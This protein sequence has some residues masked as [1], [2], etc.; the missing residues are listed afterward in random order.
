MLL[1]RSGMDIDAELMTIM[2]MIAFGDVADVSRLLQTRPELARSQL[3][4][5]ATR[6][7][8]AEYFLDEIQH[9][10]YAGHT[11]LHVAAAAYAGSVARGL[12]ALGA[13][14]AATNRRGA[15]AL[16]YAVDGNPDS[17]RWDPYAQQEM[18]SYLIE[19]GADPQAADKNG[20][21]PLLRA[22]RNR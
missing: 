11:A 13:S 3:R 16:H 7:G 1:L 6:S 9:Q 12:V 20:T 10:L 5:G 8:S 19:C 17:P 14:V 21:T 4:L 18:V 15:Q 2:R 22:V